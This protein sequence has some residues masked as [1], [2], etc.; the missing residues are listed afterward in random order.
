MSVTVRPCLYCAHAHL[1]PNL[2]QITRANDLRLEKS[3]PKYDCANTFFTNV[4]NSLPN[5]VV[6]CD[7]VDKFKFYLDKFWQY[8]DIVY[9]CKAESYGTGSQSSHY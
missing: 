3:R 4:W 8:Q 6:L 7:T 2:T 1:V 5:D 9:G